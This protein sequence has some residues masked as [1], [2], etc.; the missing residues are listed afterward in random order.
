[1][2]TIY[3]VVTVTQPLWSLLKADQCSFICVSRL[4]HRQAWR[5]GI[6]GFGSIDN[7]VHECTIFHTVS[8]EEVGFQQP[9]CLE[10]T[11]HR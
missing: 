2:L 3:D 1:M 11:R 8:D 5:C 6:P 10:K 9:V 4:Y 7:S